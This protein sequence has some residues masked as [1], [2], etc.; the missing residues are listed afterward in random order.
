MH[1][2]CLR[3]G[4]GMG[5]FYLSL[6]RKTAGVSRGLCAFFEGPGWKVLAVWGSLEQLGW[7]LQATNIGVRRKLSEEKT[8]WGLWT[9]ATWPL[10]GL[11]NSGQKHQMTIVFFKPPKRWHRVHFTGGETDSM[12]S[13]WG[14][15]TSFSIT[16]REAIAEKRRRRPSSSRFEGPC[17]WYV[18]DWSTTFGVESEVFCAC[19]DHLIFIHLGTFESHFMFYFWWSIFFQMH[20]NCNIYTF[21]ML[22]TK[23]AFFHDGPISK[24]RGIRVGG[25]SSNFQLDAMQHATCHANRRTKK[26]QWRWWQLMGPYKKHS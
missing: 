3:T 24:K 6:R 19:L 26:R 8:T 20:G 17:G 13:F 15:P 4:L 22:C 21:V 11:Q 7:L 9:R 16:S 18:L 14:D 10:G 5:I 25:K 12:C 2:I 23:R 1:P